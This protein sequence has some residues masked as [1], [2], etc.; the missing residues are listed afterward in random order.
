MKIVRARPALLRTFGA[1]VLTVAASGCYVV[2]DISV[3][4]EILG[5]EKRDVY[6]YEHPFPVDDPEFRRSAEALGSP[7]VGGNAAELF[8]NGD[9]IFPAMT[10]DI[11]EA[12]RSVNLESY[13]FQPDEAGR[14]F[15]D[16]LIAAAR[17]GV[18]VRLLV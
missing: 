4:S 2:K 16:A 7:M 11:R 12:T 1:L 5:S 15:A 13:I 8:K 9:E 17:R 3:L 18:R 14:L 10:K 6:K